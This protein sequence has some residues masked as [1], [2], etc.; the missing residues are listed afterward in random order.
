MTRPAFDPTLCLVIGPDDTLGRDP[1]WVAE[2]AMEGGVTMVQLRWKHAASDALVALGQRLAPICA[3]FDVP[4]LLDDRADLVA[5]AGAHGVHV[6]QR[7]MPV[8][9]ARAAVGP[10]AIVGLSIEDASQLGTITGDVDY[11]GVGPIFHTATKPDHAPPLGIA[12]LAALAPR[13]DV[14]AMAIG[15]VDVRVAGALREAGAAGLAVVSAIARADDPREAARAL[16]VA[17]AARAV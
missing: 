11:V 4:L 9:A 13:L 12:G 6:G 17:F 15:G 10:A 5:R 7:D 2:R 1:V 8:A 16:R 14:P 3:R